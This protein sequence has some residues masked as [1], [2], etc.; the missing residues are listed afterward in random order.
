MEEPHPL[1][2]LILKQPR[3][4]ERCPSLDGSDSDPEECCYIVPSGA[5]VV[6][7]DHNETARFVVHFLA[8][9]IHLHEVKD[10]RTWS[11]H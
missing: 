11:Y 9:G 4:Y 10:R 7:R 2:I 5:H 3:I 8:D 6:F 1:F